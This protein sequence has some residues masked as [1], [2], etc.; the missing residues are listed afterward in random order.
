MG[1]DRET[2]QDS[3]SYLIELDREELRLLIHAAAIGAPN[4]GTT[5]DVA[6]LRKLL[7]KLQGVHDG[8]A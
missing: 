8:A 5:E 6:R 1:T 7:V 4:A 2:D 3:G